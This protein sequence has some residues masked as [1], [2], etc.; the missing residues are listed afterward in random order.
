[1]HLKNFPNSHDASVLIF[2]I[3]VTSLLGSLLPSP[4]DDHN[5]EVRLYIIY[6]F[7]K[8]AAFDVFSLLP[9]CCGAA[10]TVE[11]R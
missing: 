4:V 8:T 3:K 6:C 5:S 9:M 11:S 10:A 2:S 7:Q 1:M